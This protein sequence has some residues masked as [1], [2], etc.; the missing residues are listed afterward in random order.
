VKAL[1]LEASLITLTMVAAACSPSLTPSPSPVAPTQ[2]PTP[3]PT[4]L[5]APSPSTP[6]A[7]TFLDWTAIDL[8]SPVTR[9]DAMPLGLVVFHGSYIAVGTAGEPPRGCGCGGP[10]PSINQ[11]LVWTSLDGRSWVL[12]DTIVTF[13]HAA[14]RG[15]VTDGTRLVAYG[16]YAAPIKGKDSIPVGATWVS[17]DGT[18]WT[19]SAGPAP[20]SVVAGPK[21]F[22]GA[23]ETDNYAIGGTRRASLHFVASTDGLA[24]QSTSTTFAAYLGDPSSYDAAFN[25]EGDQVLAVSG[26][27]SVLAIGML[28]VAEPTVTVV[29]RSADGLTW[30][31]PD[32]LV[33]NPPPSAVATGDDFLIGHV[34]RLLP[35]SGSLTPILF[36]AAG[37]SVDRLYV[38]GDTV[39]ATGSKD[40][41]NLVWL[42][43]DGGET[44]SPVAGQV[45]FPNVGQ[46]YVT[47]VVATPEGILA[48]GERGGT[49]SSTVPQAWFGR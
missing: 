5:P 31:G 24:W 1:R 21:G 36:P 4:S 32:T 11:G 42:S 48:V 13:K 41:G 7:V 27:G 45:P 47:A 14:L 6:A 20:S 19:R 40:Q 44:F 28:P 8:P 23:I 46:N 22:V 16:E 15:V 30:S 25:G 39:I 3:S 34:E 29:W 17:T 9:H 2:L 10:D 37:I 35:G 43:T 18:S 49:G 33:E 12:H 26:S 38:A